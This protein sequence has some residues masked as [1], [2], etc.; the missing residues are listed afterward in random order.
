[1]RVGVHC[2]GGYAPKRLQNDKEVNETRARKLTSLL[3]Q[4]LESTKH[5][6]EADGPR[7][8]DC[9]ALLPLASQINLR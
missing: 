9:T 3:R 2:A 8:S 4:A 6:E 7:R 1:M 5:H